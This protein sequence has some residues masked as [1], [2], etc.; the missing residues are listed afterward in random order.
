MVGLVRP[1]R[2]GLLRST[3]RPPADDFITRNSADAE[4]VTIGWWPGDPRYPHA[5]FY[6]FGFPAPAGSP[7]AAVSPPEARFDDDL[8][9]FVLDWD[10]V[11]AAPHPHAVALDF[12]HSVFRHL[13]GLAGWE[14]S[15]VRS[16][17]GV[18]PPLRPRRHAAVDGR[19][20]QA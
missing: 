15:L 10:D 16:A 5:A 1:Q 14:A 18:P 12:M 13:S 8:G 20:D 17:D 3:G 7:R 4:H 9:E 19:P 6:A 2:D 11:R